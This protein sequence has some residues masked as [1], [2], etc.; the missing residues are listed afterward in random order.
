MINK[1]FAGLSFLF[2]SVVASSSQDV[3]ISY[4]P[5]YFSSPAMMMTNTSHIFS[6]YYDNNTHIS[7]F[8]E[9]GE[10]KKDCTKN[11][12]CLG[13]I[14]TQT[15]DNTC[16]L[17]DTLGSPVETDITSVSL[18]KMSYFDH[19][20][21]HNIVGYYYYANPNYGI[22]TNHTVYLDLNYNG[23]WDY[24]EPIN[25]TV[26][27]NFEFSN[28][29]SGNYLVRDIQD[30]QCV[31]IWPGAWGDSTVEN[32]IPDTYVD[33][34]VQYY[35][36]G[37]SISY[38]FTG[39]Y[40]SDKE[41]SIFHFV[42]D[43][44][45]SYILGNTSD[46]FLS[47][48]PN[49][50]IVLAFL[51][52]MI[53]PNNYTS[54]IIIETFGLSDTAAYVSVSQD[55]LE[56]TF[57]GILENG[58]SGFNLSDV[59]Y[60]KNV[61]FIKMDFFNENTSNDDAIHIISVRGTEHVAYYSPFST[62]VNVPQKSEVV[63]VKDCNY[64]YKCHIYCIFSHLTFDE[65][66]SCLVG[67][68]LWDK[69]GTCMCKDYAE[70]NIL[71]EGDVFINDVCVDGCVYRI[72]HEVYPD[73]YVKMHASGVESSVSSTVNCQEYDVNG[74]SP[75]GCIRDTIESCSR[76]PSCRALSLDNHIDGMLYDN[77]HYVDEENSYFIVKNN[78]NIQNSLVRYTTTTTTTI[79]ATTITAT[80]ITAT[81]ITSTITATTV[82]ATTV[83]S[84]TVTATTVTATTI[85]ATTITATTITATT[86]T[87]TITS[88]TIT[89]TI[90]A[91]TAQEMTNDTKKDYS[92]W[93]SNLFVII[94]AIIS[95]V[96]FVILIAM[97]IKKNNTDIN[98][99]MR[100][101]PQ[102]FSNPIYDITVNDVDSHPLPSPTLS[103]IS[104]TSTSSVTTISSV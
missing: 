101:H 77:Y 36:S 84:T 94:F 42:L 75:N 46:T 2:F 29:S 80:T 22:D 69:T 49:D 63:F 51:D 70:N 99:V 21:K 30:D 65:Q 35:H 45:S 47:F 13:I 5:T 62:Y 25:T 93:N 26:N 12:L 6:S 38:V 87:S 3:S 67:C 76:Q 81:T 7:S 92:L 39:G 1:I 64:Y 73:Y 34:V 9:L 74:L 32:Y 103:Q 16:L 96:L 57:I 55:N 104:K 102:T 41:S 66:D 100:I 27:N 71:F 59:N 79:T 68:D 18:T 98:D 82:T 31:Q 43:A 56:Y 33:G 78:G 8:T 88:T 37:H 90:T 11:S 23:V 91:T 28:V 4:S 40:I 53:V 14:E 89:A 15:P 72:K 61:A 24:T 50:G 86:V 10:C 20:D 95:V 19:R 60:S 52:E 85:T 44:P 54:D 83:T 58:N 17:V 48:K 97:C